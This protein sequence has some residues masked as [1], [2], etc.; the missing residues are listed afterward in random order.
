MDV[1]ALEAFY[2]GGVSQE[3]GH[4]VPESSPEELADSISYLISNR[5]SARKIAAAGRELIESRFNLRTNVAELR[6]LFERVGVSS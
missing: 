2:V 5:E 1:K 6:E 3:T 4:I